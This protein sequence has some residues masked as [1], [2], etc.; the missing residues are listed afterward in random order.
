FD[1]KT[2]GT[3]L[4]EHVALKKTETE[5]EQARKPVAPKARPGDYDEYPEIPLRGLGHRSKG[6][7]VRLLNRGELSSPGDVVKPGLPAK[8]AAGPM[9]G[10]V[11]REKWRAVLADWGASDRNPRTVRVLVNRVWGWHFGQGL[12]R[13]PNDFGVRGER[14]THPELLDRLAV[15]FVESGWSLKHLHRLILLSNAYRMSSH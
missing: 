7:E 3:V 15:E 11:P 12:V 4:R 10:D 1:F 14:P 13:P 2:D 6:L 8:L 5:F 9:L